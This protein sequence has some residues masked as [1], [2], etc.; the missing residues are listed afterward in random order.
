[1]NTPHELHINCIKSINHEAIDEKAVI[2]NIF[3]AREKTIKLVSEIK[4]NLVEGINEIQARK[5][6]LEI[7]YS[8]GVK[9]HWHQPYIRFGSG[10]ALSFKEPL[11]RENN[12]TVD[13][14]FYIDLG[15]VWSD[16]DL[17]LEYEGDYGDT[18]VYG[19]NVEAEKCITTART[20]F[21]EAKGK[22]SNQEL[23]GEQI[24][25]YINNRCKELEYKLAEDFDGHRVSDFPHHKYTLE[26]LANINFVP[27]K[28]LWILELQIKDPE[29][30]FGAFYEDIL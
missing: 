21:Q 5:L 14:P 25:S 7:S 4:E 10:T 17:G 19:Q 3:C 29:D 18:F 24:Y 27:S 28:S 13:S 9:K 23:T 11:C 2:E 30:R 12:L 16:L 15:P 1:M 20:L 26:R 22:W 6:A 8:Y